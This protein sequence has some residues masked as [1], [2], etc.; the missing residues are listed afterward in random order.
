MLVSVIIALAIALYLAPGL[1]AVLCG[2]PQKG[3]IVILTALSG[4]TLIGW[5][6]C[7]V[8]ACRE[9]REASDTAVAKRLLVVEVE[10][11]IRMKRRGQ[12]T[13]AEYAKRR[14]MLLERY[15]G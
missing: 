12:L 3:R 2:H 11:L 8:W 7:L 14:K 13:S 1:V 4:W 15:G 6:A 9:P 5:I 10:D